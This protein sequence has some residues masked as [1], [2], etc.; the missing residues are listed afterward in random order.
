[1]EDDDDSAGGGFGGALHQKLGPFP[2]W[3]YLL[4]ITI[5][6]FAYY[7]VSKHKAGNGS[8]GAT[9]GQAQPGEVTGDQNVPDY[10]FQN[11]T[12]VVEPPESNTIS[13]T[14]PPVSPPSAPSTP[15]PPT[16]PTPTPKPPAKTTTPP[17]K[18]QKYTTVTVVKW[19]AQHTPWN[20]TLSGIADHYGV[21]GGY[22]TLAKLNGIKNPNLIYPGQKIK[23]PVS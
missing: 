19:T 8:S 17:S 10:V 22:Q 3:I 12:N 5:G 18:A 1:M 16:A 23:V 7:L 20:S 21:K 15:K 13:I 9:S 14:N 4:V 2:T 6:L 11:T